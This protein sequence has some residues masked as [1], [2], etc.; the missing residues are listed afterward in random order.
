MTLKINNKILQLG[1]QERL[2]TS[3]VI[4][5]YHAVIVSWSWFKSRRHVEVVSQ[6]CILAIY[7]YTSQM[8]SV[9]LPVKTYLKL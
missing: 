1:K 3:D 5:K 7:G 8:A 4:F 6:M 2:I 9:I